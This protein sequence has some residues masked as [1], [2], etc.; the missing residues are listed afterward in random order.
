MIFG[1]EALFINEIRESYIQLEIVKEG[2]TQPNVKV[3]G[4]K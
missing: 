2:I 1:H 3:G 4:I